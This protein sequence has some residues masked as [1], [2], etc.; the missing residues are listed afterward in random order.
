MF[1]P[2]EARRHRRWAASETGLPRW[3]LARCLRPEAVAP[4]CTKARI[5]AGGEADHEPLLCLDWKRNSSFSRGLFTEAS[6][7][8]FVGVVPVR[9]AQTKSSCGAARFCQTGFHPVTMASNERRKLWEITYL[10]FV[11]VLAMR[12]FRVLLVWGFS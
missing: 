6:L 2:S 3:L 7:P 9:V 12:R 8:Q 1:L 4:L 5:R 11:F 10:L